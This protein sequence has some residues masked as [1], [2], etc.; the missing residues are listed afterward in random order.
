MKLLVIDDDVAGLEIRRLILERY[1]FEVAAA[2]DA[3]AARTAFAANRPDAV[4]LDLRLPDVADGLA[5][6]RDFQGVR[7]IVL[8]GNRADLDGREEAGLVAAILGKPVRSEELVRRIRGVQTF[9]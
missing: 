1:G 4:V 6:I 3:E 2:G 5:L 7:I 9:S 8:T